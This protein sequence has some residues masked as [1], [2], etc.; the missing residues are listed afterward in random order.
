MPA[1]CRLSHLNSRSRSVE[2]FKAMST[3]HLESFDIEIEF[4][5]GRLLLRP[6]GQ[7]TLH[8]P[9]PSLLPVLDNLRKPELKHV[10]FDCSALQAWDSRFV[11]FAR[12]LS[13]RCESGNIVMESATLPG[14]VVKLL[15]LADAAAQRTDSM[16]AAPEHRF[17]NE[18]GRQVMAFIRSAGELI[19]FT[20]EAAVAFVRMLR[21]KARFRHRDLFHVMQEVGAEALPIVSLTSVLLGLILAYI[22]SLQLTQFGAD[23]YVA[24]L[25]AIAMSRE[26]AAMMTGIILAGRTGAAFAAQLGTM[27]ANEE[28]DALRTAA[29]P[30]MEFLVLPRII[31]LVLM[32][33]VLTIYANLMGMIGGAAVGVFLLDIE[34]LQYA[35]QTRNSIDLVDFA[36]GLVKACAYGVIVAVSGCLRGMQ[37]GRSAAAV[38]EAATS[39]VVTGIV[40]IVVCS[41]TLTVIYQVLGI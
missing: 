32:L 2:P 23:E 36:T 26:M 29:I 18:I 37:S 13:Q 15:E 33:P 24:N 16:V 10:A 6:V 7:W 1:H 12:D 41:A 8:A 20:G 31:A 25:V 19:E 38:G 17:L 4:A 27:M 40:F 30:P 11:V 9:L 5:D 22:G 35:V 39:A 28:I 3:E 14:G 21:G 34:P